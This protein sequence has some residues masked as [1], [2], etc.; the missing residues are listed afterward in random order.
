MEVQEVLLAAGEAPDV[1]D[2]L[3]FDAHAMQRRT[4]SD[5]GDDQRS[6]VLETDEPTIEQ[7]IDARRKQ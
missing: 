5:G 3:G 4:M 1:D 6:I 2:P 7:V